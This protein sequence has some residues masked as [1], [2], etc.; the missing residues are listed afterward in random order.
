[1]LHFHPI[2]NR[3]GVHTLKPKYGQQLNH[4]SKSLL[5]LV[6]HVFEIKKKK[7]ETTDDLH[8]INSCTH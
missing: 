1:M 3:T 6:L 2:Q 8:Q 7:T 4:P 5:M